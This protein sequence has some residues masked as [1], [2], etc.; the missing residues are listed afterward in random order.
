MKFLIPLL[1]L[2][3]PVF[4][5]STWKDL[6]SAE[7]VLET[8]GVLKDQ[9]FQIGI[10][11]DLK[12]GWHTYWKNSGDSGAGPNLDWG[13]DSAQVSELH[14]PAPERFVDAGLT[15]FGF[16][17]KT[18]FVVD[19]KGL[20]ESKPIKLSMEWLVCKEICI[21]AITDLW[22]TPKI[23][24][25]N[26]ITPSHHA[27]F[28]E[29][30]RSQWPILGDGQISMQDSVAQY[31]LTPP[32]EWEEFDFFPYKS[33]PFSTLSVASASQKG[34]LPYQWSMNLKA[35]A[36]VG[37]LSGIAVFK[38]G[39]SVRVIEVLAPKISSQS[40]FELLTLL[41]LAFVGGLILNLMPCVFP[42]LSLK[43]FGILKSGHQ[44][45]KRIRR[46]NLGYVAG[47]LAAFISLGLV[48]SLI[49][50]L[51]VH[52][53][54]GF[55]LQSP[56]FVGALVLLFV[57][58]ALEMLGFYE[59]NLI[60]PNRGNS[61][62]RTQGLWGSF[63]T[64]VLAVVVASPCAA[65][66]MGAAVGAALARGGFF[67]LLIFAALGFGL[68]FPYLLLAISPRFLAWLPKPGQWMKTL[69]E[70][71]AFPMLLTAVW[72]TWLFLQITDPASVLLLLSVIV[73]IVF[74]IWLSRFYKPV[75]WVVGVFVVGSFLYYLASMGPAESMGSAAAA[76]E[77]VEGDWLSFSEERVSSRKPKEVIFVN[78]TADWCITCKV[79]ERLVFKD[80]HV[81]E[82]FLQNKI[83]K[84][85]G[86]WTRRDS[87]IT[88]F[89]DRFQRAGVPF[90]V[91]FS[92]KYPMGK[93]LNE[94]MT[95]DSLIG[96]IRDSLN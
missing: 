38:K 63:F 62:T 7:L 89:L 93:P 69:K 53:G 14:F 96:D 75:A 12:P 54:W 92:D 39:D 27:D 19:H 25:E 45:W 37:D 41:F 74:S 9:P 33:L 79:N 87:R 6:T 17:N 8:N 23:L 70:F 1:F 57:L 16:E 34:T 46:E 40:M 94:L 59:I 10:L 56:A 82:Y 11:I 47:V 72:L 20:S 85:K 67:A 84:L 83:T 76:G 77:A 36:A 78:M 88:A 32:E 65:P 4:A 81:E 44:D 21:P 60:D 18:L 80:K 3:L 71:M 24:P 64:G 52:V 58:L 31:Q 48:L 26:Q 95:V 13:S 43:L 73:G 86:D 91:V 35:E 42:I 15:T 29:R 61:L 30:A 66:F 2:C 55:Q 50:N 28:F 90:Y 51:G 49:R 68:A 22:I 5:Q